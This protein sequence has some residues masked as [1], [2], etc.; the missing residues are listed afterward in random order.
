[1]GAIP[2]ENVIGSQEMC[3]VVQGERIQGEN[4]KSTGTYVCVLW[5][6]RRRGAT[7]QEM[8]LSFA[9]VLAQHLAR[10]TCSVNSDSVTG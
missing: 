5:P 1:M 8:V 6:G 10:V 2:V 3:E 9:S 4:S 7:Q